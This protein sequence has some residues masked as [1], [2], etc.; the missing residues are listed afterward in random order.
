MIDLN[1]YDKAILDELTKATKVVMAKKGVERNSNLLKTVEWE[2]KQN[3]FVLLANDYY[4]YVSSGRKRGA[5]KVPITDLIPWIKKYNIRPTAGQTINQL[6]FAIQSSI[7]KSGIRGKKFEDPVENVTLDMITEG[8]AEILSE[9]IAN[10]IAD[11]I[12][13]V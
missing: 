2:K 7:Y 6:A 3:G 4:Q 5:R 11:S 9:A 10:G 12:N 8:T 1:K 13:K